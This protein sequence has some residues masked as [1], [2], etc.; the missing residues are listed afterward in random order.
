MESRYP[1]L[2][3]TLPVDVRVQCQPK[4]NGALPGLLPGTRGSPLRLEDGTGATLYLSEYRLGTGRGVTADIVVGTT[5]CFV[6]GL[7]SPGEFRRLAPT[8]RP[9]G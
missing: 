4:G 6:S 2:G 3:Q 8:L 9:L 1:G 7:I 5:V